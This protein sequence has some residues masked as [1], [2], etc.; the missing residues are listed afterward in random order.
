MST[1]FKELFGKARMDVS[2]DMKSGNLRKSNVY[3]DSKQKAIF[4]SVKEGI[5]NDSADVF[6]KASR[7]C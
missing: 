4:E 3:A 5:R 6:S 1:Q 2:S 7:L